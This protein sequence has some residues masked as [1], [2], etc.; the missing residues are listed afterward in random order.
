[1][2]KKLLINYWNSYYNN[3]IK[4]KESSFA[5]FVK[6]KIN[7]VKKNAKLIDIGCGNGRDSFFFSKNGL[8]V[9]AIDIS[10]KAIANNSLQQDPN[11]KFIRLDV[12]R[13]IMSGK[14]DLIYCRFF[15]HAINDEAKNKLV[16]LLKKIKK[17]NTLA[18]FEFR[19]HKDKIFKK[20]G[21]KHNDI[22]EFEKG[23][24][25]RVINPN[26]FIKKIKNKIK[27]K[28]VYKRSSKNLSIVK[29]DNPNLSR[30]IFKF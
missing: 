14:F 25:R 26:E 24:F 6:K 10:N 15:L 1:M 3:N 30:V 12:A 2:K 13:N 18:F 23:H 11:L 8:K 16:L 22:I 17:K 7:K 20:K 19:N 5:R 21:R 28:V 27:C 4:F 9:T 29:K